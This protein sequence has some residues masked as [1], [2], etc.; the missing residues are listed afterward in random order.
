MR[1]SAMLSEE[2]MPNS[3]GRLAAGG[4]KSV[5]LLCFLFGVLVMASLGT[6]RGSA[7]A[8]P[9]HVYELRIYH[10]NAG[11]LDALQARFGDH[12]DALFRR[13]NMKSVGYWRPEE[14]P[15]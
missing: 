2:V 15:G 10:A 1:R 8:P 14:A 3:H 6:L 5:Y 11:K 4:S 12:T 13:H 9:N 7:A